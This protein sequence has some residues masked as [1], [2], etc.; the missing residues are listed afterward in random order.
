MA[1]FTI[2]V[3]PA[4]IHGRAD[5]V[6]AWEIWFLAEPATDVDAFEVAGV[7]RCK[8]LGHG[9]WVELVLHDSVIIIDGL[10]GVGLEG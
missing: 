6:E 8:D 5:A 2:A 7:T 9:T 4:L 1:G 3:V 10:L